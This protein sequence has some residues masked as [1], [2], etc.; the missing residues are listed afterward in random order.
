MEN[1]LF[2][3]IRQNLLSAILVYLKVPI[4]FHKSEKLLYQKYYNQ[5]PIKREKKTEIIIMMDGTFSH[6]GLAD[7]LRGICSIFQYCKDKG[8]PF[9]IYHTH[10]YSLDVYLTPNKYDWR[11]YQN[12]ISR[13]K[14]ESCLLFIHKSYLSCFWQRRYLE[15]EIKRNYGKQIHVYTN[16][17]FYDNY[18]SLN[19]NYLFKPSFLLKKNLEDLQKQFPSEYYV[20]TFRFQQLLGDFTDPGYYEIN[21]E[22]GKQ[23]LIESCINKVLEIRSSLP[24]DSSIIIAGDSQVFIDAICNRYNW[25][26]SIPGEIGHVDY[27]GKNC[28]PV[29]LKTF[30]DFY[31]LSRAKAIYFLVTGKMYLQSGFALRASY[32]NKTPFHI[33]RF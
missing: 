28:Q 23:R 8:L 18:Y 10:P 20:M 27:C 5:S 26:L 25:A 16:A 19:Y 30:I 1:R 11:I 21:G 3:F 14:S 33:I 24:S 9:Y 17:D 22:Q 32:I 4:S 7:R 2:G 31:M 13:N 15:I 12:Q 29:Y 6:G